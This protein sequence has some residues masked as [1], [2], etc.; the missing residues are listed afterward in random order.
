M[1]E[2]PVVL[3]HQADPA[4]RRLHEHVGGRVVDH[5]I[6]D[7][8]PARGHRR[9]AGHRSQERGLAGTVGPEDGHHLARR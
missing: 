8:E 1:R 4:L 3:E 9:E 5:D 6:A 2:E 7:G